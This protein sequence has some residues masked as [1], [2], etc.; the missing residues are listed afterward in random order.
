MKLK[1]K[2]AFARPFSTVNI[3]DVGKGTAYSQEGMTLREYY[4]GLAM[5]GIMSGPGGSF[6]APDT[7]ADMAVNCADV[8]IA[9]LEKE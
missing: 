2:P 9:E 3:N 8:L 1:D 6:H 4:A 7:L 5:Q